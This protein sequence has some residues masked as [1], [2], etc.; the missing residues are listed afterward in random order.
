M[1]TG[2]HLVMAVPG[3]KL[4]PLHAQA[5]EM[6]MMRCLERGVDLSIMPEF[7]SGIDLARNITVAKFLELPD[8]T[9]LLFVD[10]DIAFASDSVFA[11]LE[12]DL[13]VC[14]AIYPKKVVD[15]AA[16]AQASKNG[17]PDAELK[18]H[19]GQFVGG[20]EAGSRRSKTFG[21]HRFVEADKL[22]TGFMLIKRGAL[23][24][25]IAYHCTRI[26]HHSHWEPKGLQHTV[27]LSEL[28]G[29]RQKARDRLLATVERYGRHASSIDELV[30][31]VG[32]YNIAIAG[33]VDAYQ[34]EDYSFTVRAK[35][36]GIGCWMYLD[37]EIA[38]QGTWVFEGQI[39]KMVP[40]KEAGRDGKPTV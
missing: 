35:E 29:P 27:F 5:R 21:K 40:H 23:E 11:M 1:S 37:A 15:Y 3:W 12:A 13:D 2:V 30:S 22:G 38:H 19:A 31:A 10:S 34:T 36:A 6:L 20:A 8:A 14:G 16:V 7:S 4:S 26:E 32:R 18:Y 24:K 39:G 9:H 17:V 25:F 28:Q 33:P